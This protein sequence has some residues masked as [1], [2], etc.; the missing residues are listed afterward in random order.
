MT[1]GDREV[2]TTS[3]KN[4]AGTPHYSHHEVQYWED[5][6]PYYE[7]FV[8]VHSEVTS[9]S[10]GRSSDGNAQET[11]ALTSYHR[12]IDEQGVWENWKI[13]SQP[14]EANP[15]QDSGSG[16]RN[17]AA[18]SATM[19]CGM[20][21]DEKFT[22]F[23]YVGEEDI[24]GV[25]TK[26]FIG[27]DDPYGAEDPDFIQYEYWIALTGFPVQFKV[28]RRM[29][30]GGQFDELV[31]VT[32]YS[33]W[34]EQNVINPPTQETSPAATPV[35]TAP[36]P[37]TLEPTQ[38]P[39]LEPTQEPTLES[40]L[41]AT[42]E[43]TAE[44]TPVS[45]TSEAWLEPDP[46]SVT[47]ANGQWREFTLR[48]TGLQNVDLSINVFNSNG[49]S[50]TGA[51]ELAAGSALPSASDACLTTSFTGYGVWV[52]FTF[53]LVGCQAGTVIIWLLDAA[54]DFAL[55]REYAVTVS[56]GP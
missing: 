39:T 18:A 42:P 53:N 12:S 14:I 19:F 15:S 17:A 11:Y 30:V 31:T 51:V 32:T 36:V 47:F 21:V 50:S 13:Q 28:N 44:P 25:R 24:D 35:P 54:N 16:T 48:G 33:G 41:E 8:V 27:L 34:G 7:S 26:H 3:E 5:G 10:S 43:P 20:N 9:G 1:Q 56:G 45:S 52:G 38:E 4:I 46:E 37:P 22:S 49:P 40:T 29:D 2:I 23:R 6:T 55:I